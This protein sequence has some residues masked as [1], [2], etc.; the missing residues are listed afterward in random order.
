M[1]EE[2]KNTIR[3]IIPITDALVVETEIDGKRYKGTLYPVEQ[4]AQKPPVI[5]IDKKLISKGY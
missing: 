5:R 4:Q 2:E 1:S 3:G